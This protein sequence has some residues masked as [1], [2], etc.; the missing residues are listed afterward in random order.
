MAVVMPAR[1]GAELAFIG[2]IRGQP[3]A[4]RRIAKKIESGHRPSA[5]VWRNTIVVERLW[6]SVKYEKVYL[7]ADGAVSEGRARSIGI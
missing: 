7:R 2:Q 4:E 1:C 5:K 6:R 3:S